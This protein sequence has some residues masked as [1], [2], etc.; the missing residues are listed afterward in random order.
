M[1]ASTKLPTN[2]KCKNQCVASPS[3]MLQGGLLK[4]LG[5]KSLNVVLGGSG[6]AGRIMA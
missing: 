3:S 2:G 4:I 6:S 1:K 5:S